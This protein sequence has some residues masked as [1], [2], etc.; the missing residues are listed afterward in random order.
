MFLART[1]S[2]LQMQAGSPERAEEMAS[3]G[4]LQWLLGLRPDSGYPAEARRA[5]D[6]AAPFAGTDPAVAAFCDL[7]E[8]SLAR[9]P[10]PLDLTVPKPRRRGGAK[11]RRLRL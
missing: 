9:S 11:S 10:L 6:A 3:L 5:L 2:M 7:I 1:I 8:Q 4:Y